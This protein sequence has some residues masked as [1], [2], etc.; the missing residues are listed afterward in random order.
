[1]ISG[2][3]EH[4]TA[5]AHDVGKRCGS[6]CLGSVRSSFTRLLYYCQGHHLAS[7]GQS[8]FSEHIFAWD[9]GP[10]AAT[11]WREELEK[12]PRPEP[13]TLGEAELNTVGYVVSRYGKMNGNDLERLSHTEE[14]WI[15]GD[16]RRKRGESDRIDLESIR[17]FFTTATTVRDDEDPRR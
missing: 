12:L 16:Q 14:P 3:F 10:V 2:R 13:H 5:S 11:L 15:A 4:M 17:E 6:G 8:L 9:M 1:M 7:F